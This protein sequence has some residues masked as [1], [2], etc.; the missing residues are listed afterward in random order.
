MN[1]STIQWNKKIIALAV[2]AVIVHA[3]LLFAVF[4]RFSERSSSSAYNQDVF[5][6]GYDYLADN[7]VAGNG[8]RFYPDTAPTL[9]REPGYP[10]LVAGLRLMFGP[11]L[12]AVKLVNMILAFAA[13]WLLLVIVSRLTS[14]SW[15]RF[16]APLMFLFHPG[17]IVA[18][19]RAGVEILFGSLVLF[20][21]WTLIKATDKERLRDFLIS[22]LVLGLSVLVRSVL[23][24]FPAFLLIYLLTVQRPRVPIRVALRNVGAMV[25]AMLL[26]LSPW[27]LRNYFLTGRFIPTASVLGVSAQAGQYINSHLSEGRPWWLLDREAAKERNRIAE[28]LGFQFEPGYYQCFYRTGDEIAFSKALMDRV[29][30]SYKASP[31]LLPK[32]VARNFFNFWF[33]GKTEKATTANLFVQLPYLLLA[34]VGVVIGLRN[35]KG[36]VVWLILLL[37]GYVVA[38]SLPILAQA[39]YGVP[40]VPL[41]SILGAFGLLGIEKARSSRDGKLALDPVSNAEAGATTIKEEKALYVASSVVEQTGMSLQQLGKTVPL[42]PNLRADVYLSIVIPAY[43]E[44]QRLPRTVLETLSFCTQRNLSFEIILSDDG[45]LD[46]TL[47]LARL[48]EERDAR[49]RAMSCPHLGKGSAVRMGMLNARGQFVLF[50]D[51][52]GATPL[53]EISKLIAALEAGNDVA[54]GSR[55]LQV[56]G[57]VRVKTSLHRRFIGRVFAFFVNVIAIGGVADTQCGFKMFRR[58]AAQAIFPLQKT[59]GFAFDVEILFLARKLGLALIEV[60]VNW[61][62]QPGSKVNLVSDSMKMLWDITQI[63]WMHR[64]FNFAGRPV[65]HFARPLNVKSEV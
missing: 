12:V 6:D 53:T 39:R 62:A 64:N 36:N 13:A 28:Q 22:G 24:L 32:V 30:A 18:E 4:P 11:S 63:R 46:T 17:T 38:V 7:L 60:P 2:G 35:H 29:V 58:D 8:Y 55:A 44:E 51:A 15:A 3:V 43:N 19:G 25:L 41:L 1:Q 54:F 14:G 26:V 48:F 23:I 5:A 34:A 20:F 52:D 31:G 65:R 27:I 45:S 56:A 42:Q 9:M 40:L 49:V 33:A 61:V 47:E 16:V 57:D 50:M 37:I 59:P 10:I 21:F